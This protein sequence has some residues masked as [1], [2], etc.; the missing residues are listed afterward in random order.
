MLESKLIIIPALVHQNKETWTS[1]AWLASVLM[2]QCGN[3]NELA[4]QHGGFYTMR[5]FVAKGLLMLC[6]WRSEAILVERTIAKKFFGN[7]TLLSS[8]AWATLR[9][10]F[11]HHHGRL[12]TWL[13][14]QNV[15]LKSKGR[16]WTWKM[17]AWL[18]QDVTHSSVKFR[19]QEIFVRKPWS[20]RFL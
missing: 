12:I 8:N 11:D 10:W 13:Q 19:R 14:S 3:N 17:L 5:S 4:L 16:T 20:F 6:T 18:F 1:E 2:S 7:L 9:Y 15:F